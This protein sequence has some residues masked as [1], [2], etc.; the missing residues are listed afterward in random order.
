ME[1]AS[2]DWMAR[3]ALFELLSMGLLVPTPKLAGA[4]ADGEYAA[5]AE[6]AAEACELELGA[7]SRL[8]AYSGREIDGL[9]H[10][11]RRERTALFARAPEPAITPCV[12]V[13]DAR[14]HGQR[15]LLFVGRESMAIERFMRR[16][17][18]AKDLA[19][20]QSN[21]PVDHVGTVC[22]FMKY[23]CLVNARAIEPGAGAEVR[24]DDFE[25]F[26]REHFR[27]YA[28]WCA[29][30]IRKNDP[31]PF[32]AFVANALEQAAMRF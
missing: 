21:D 10:E 9:F 20:G 29:G 3:A 22:E 11:L 16:C 7:S 15:G 13:W 28:I 6:E 17:G 31:S 4:L 23:L 27:D 8:A 2:C 19:A 24:E 1:A 18:V 30:E 5:A 14:R 32:Y 12:G 25:V 26:H